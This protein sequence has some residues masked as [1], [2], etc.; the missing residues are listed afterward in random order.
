[1]HERSASTPK[2]VSALFIS[3]AAAL[4]LIIDELSGRRSV[5]PLLRG[6]RLLQAGTRLVMQGQEDMASSFRL[7]LL[8]NA[9]LDLFNT[10]NTHVSGSS[11]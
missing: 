5:L 3:S 8:F 7:W 11:Y 9:P 1:M 2:P 10:P 6:K 4:Q